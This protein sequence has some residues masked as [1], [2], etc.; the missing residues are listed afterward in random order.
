MKKK[1]LASCIPVLYW[2]HSYRGLFLDQALSLTVWWPLAWWRAGRDRPTS[3]GGNGALTHCHLRLLHTEVCVCVCA[4]AS[5]CPCWCQC[6]HILWT[7]VRSVMPCVCVIAYLCVKLCVCVCIDELSWE[8]WQKRSITHNGNCK[9]GDS[10]M[11]KDGEREMRAKGR[12]CDGALD[13]TPPTA[14]VVFRASK[15]DDR[16][17]M[18]TI[19]FFCPQWRCFIKK[20]LHKMTVL[21]LLQGLSNLHLWMSRLSEISLR[22]V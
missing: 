21:W 1:T 6:F 9:R 18:T 4:S 16:W 3:E 13:F 11:V 12:Y 10:T 17:K 15:E 14:D 19:G 20:I 5:I 2:L 22:A 8:Q 7:H